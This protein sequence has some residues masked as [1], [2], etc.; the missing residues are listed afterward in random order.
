MVEYNQC[1]SMLSS[2]YELGLGAKNRDEFAAYR[3]LMFL[4]GLNRS[5]SCSPH[6]DNVTVDSPPPLDLNLFVGQLTSE[7]KSN[8]CVRHALNVQRALSMGN[9]HL[10]F[11]L[12]NTVPNMGGYIMDHFVQRER[13]RALLVMS[14]SYAPQNP[15]LPTLTSF[16]HAGTSRYL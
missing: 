10:F 16:P 15:S 7:Q 6:N 9:Y 11:S 5:G 4:H 2:L 1:Q 12:Y 14:K 13:I 8:P 3:I